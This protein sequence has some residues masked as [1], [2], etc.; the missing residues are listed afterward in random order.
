MVVGFQQSVMCS[1]LFCESRY[2]FEAVLT[3]RKW[4]FIAIAYL[5]NDSVLSAMWVF[6]ISVVVFSVVVLWKPYSDV[7]HQRFVRTAHGVLVSQT[8]WAANLFT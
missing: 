8:V 2:L 4:S 6:A 1:S 5:V 3:A 7:E